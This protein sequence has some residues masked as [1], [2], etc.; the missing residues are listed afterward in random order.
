MDFK[1]IFESYSKSILKVILS[2]LV[3]ALPFGL[4]YYFLFKSI[5]MPILW[6]VYLT[7][8]QT[9]ILEHFYRQVSRV[10]KGEE[11]GWINSWRTTALSKFILISLILWIFKWFG[12]ILYASAP[13][14][15]FNVFLILGLAIEFMLFF[16]SYVTYMSFIVYEVDAEK[17][18]L[19]GIGEAFSVLKQ[20]PLFFILSGCILYLISLIPY[21]GST[22]G[23]MI[24]T[25]IEYIRTGLYIEDSG[26]MQDDDYNYDYDDYEY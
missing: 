1:I 10:A 4:L 14:S 19:E 13:I 24:F 2:V 3:I 12:P 25:F 17:G 21:V 7:L 6:S 11:I 5:Y 20:Y 15:S 16:L 23:I 8:A 18:L 22:I 9:V 26:Y